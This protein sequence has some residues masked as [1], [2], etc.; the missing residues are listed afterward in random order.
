[1]SLVKS[2]WSNGY[3]EVVCNSAGERPA[4]PYDPHD[5][6]YPGWAGVIDPWGVVLDFVDGEG[7]AEA[8]AVCRLDTAVLIDRRQHPN[9]LAQE[10]R[11]ELYQ[12]EA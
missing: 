4:G 9:F 3:F 8:M 7:N 12:F 2:A 6:K 1:M 10:L 11:P 5:R